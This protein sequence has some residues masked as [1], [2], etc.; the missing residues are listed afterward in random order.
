MSEVA[1]MA[2]LGYTLG[3]PSRGIDPLSS[4]KP[5]KGAPALK[6]RK[7]IDLHRAGSLLRLFRALSLGG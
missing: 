7:N 5:T 2:A 4:R 6:G 3:V 1:E